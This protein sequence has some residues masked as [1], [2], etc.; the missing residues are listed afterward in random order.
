MAHSVSPSE[1]PRLRTFTETA[2]SSSSNRPSRR[3]A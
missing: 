3:A 2:S 1:V